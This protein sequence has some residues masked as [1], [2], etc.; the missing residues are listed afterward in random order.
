L[1]KHTIREYRPNEIYASQ[2]INMFM[3]HTL[4]TNEDTDLKAEA[5]LTE[6]IDQNKKILESR[7]SKDTISKLINMLTGDSK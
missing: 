4:S 5:T 1:I 3:N 7:I 6:L 2:W